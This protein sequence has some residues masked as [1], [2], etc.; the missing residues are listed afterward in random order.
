MFQLVL[1]DGT[2][3]NIVSSV[4]DNRL[5]HWQITSDGGEIGTGP[6]IESACRSLDLFHFATDIQKASISSSVATRFN[7]G[8]IF[9]PVRIR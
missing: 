7:S 9:P 4:Y 1:S 3:I 8:T 6:T 2:T 5:S